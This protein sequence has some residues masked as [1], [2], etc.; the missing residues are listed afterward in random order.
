VQITYAGQGDRSVKTVKCTYLAVRSFPP[1]TEKTRQPHV[2]TA[3]HLWPAHSGTK[4]F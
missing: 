4:S 3:L 1:L 2:L